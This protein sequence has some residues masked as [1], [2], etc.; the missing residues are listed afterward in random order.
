MQTLLR[1]QMV[2]ALLLSAVLALTGCV[3]TPPVVSE[4]DDGTPPPYG[5]I[6]PEDAVRVILAS[7]DDPSFVLLDIRTAGEVADG[8]LSGTANLDFYSPTFRDELAQLDRDRIYLIYCRTGN[9][10]GQT[11]TIMAE[12]GFKKVYDLDGGIR[13]WLNRNYP[14]C[15]GSLG[16]TH[17]CNGEYPEL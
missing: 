12:L 11:R 9:R 6:S 8:H 17:T 10:T 3:G 16:S 2:V 13:V 14:V 15:V 5:L 4:P 7:Q 1:R